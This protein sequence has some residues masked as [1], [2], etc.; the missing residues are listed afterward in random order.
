MIIRN[1]A[2]QAAKGEVEVGFSKHFW[3]EAEDCVPGLSKNDVYTALRSG[4][5]FGAPVRDDE[6]VCHKAKVRA[7]LA[8]FG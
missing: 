7:T 2:L 3:E 5:V 6:Y 4:T 8:D 1:V